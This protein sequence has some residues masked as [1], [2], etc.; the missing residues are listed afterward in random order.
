MDRALDTYMYAP[1]QPY[2]E[3]IS[4]HGHPK[5]RGQ[6][7]IKLKNLLL[8]GVVYVL[9]HFPIK[10]AKMTLQHLSNGPNGQNLKIRKIRGSHKIA[11]K[12]IISDLQT[13][14]AWSFFKIS[15]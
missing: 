1:S 6:K 13:S 2:G 12:L 11:Y 8:G 14:K 7:K 9:G 10:N 5:S 15:A 4:G 3:H